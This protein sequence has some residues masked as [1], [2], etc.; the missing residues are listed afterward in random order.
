[1]TGMASDLAGF[2]QPYSNLVSIQV[3]QVLSPC[4]WVV[5]MGD[6]VDFPVRI[7]D[8]NLNRRIADGTALILV[9]DILKARVETTP[10]MR[11]SRLSTRGRRILEIRSR[12]DIGTR[13]WTAI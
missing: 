6:G 9:G 5:S 8:E 12:Y 10:C 7:Q 13:Q 3:K 1:M 11:G 4:E 2:L